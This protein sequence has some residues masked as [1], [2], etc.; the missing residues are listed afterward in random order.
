MIVFC[1]LIIAIFHAAPSVEGDVSFTLKGVTKKSYGA[2]LKSFRGDVPVE[3]KTVFGIPLLR[4][5]VTGANRYTRIHLSDRDDHTITLAID[6]TNVYVL[7]FYTPKCDVSHFFNDSAAIQ[8]KK[9]VF[10]NSKGQI[11]LPF[12]GSYSKLQRAGG[13]REKLDLGLVALNFNIP[14]LFDY[15]CPNSTQTLSD[16]AKACVVVI[17]T[18]SEAARFQKIENAVQ[19]NKPP[20]REILSLENN[21]GALSKQVQLADPNTGRFKATVQLIGETGNPVNV[22]DVNSPYVKGNLQL[23]LNQQNVQPMPTL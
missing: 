3:S 23:L 9:Y 20:T 17:Q 22:M 8:A 16:V 18:I 6:V 19:N 13:D 21:W 1:L 10:T 11:T 4:A 12:D 7:G 2:F 14:K 15:S 5:T